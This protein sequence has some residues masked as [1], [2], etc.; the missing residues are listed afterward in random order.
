[1]FA[2]IGSAYVPRST[3]QNRIPHKRH[4]ERINSITRSLASDLVMFMIEDRQLHLKSKD[5]FQ[6]IRF[7]NIADWR[8]TAFQSKPEI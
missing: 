2:E 1:M 6:N 3:A 7:P 8:P 5:E 4:R